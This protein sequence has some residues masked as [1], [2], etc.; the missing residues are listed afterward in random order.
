MGPGIVAMTVLG[1]GIERVLQRDWS[2]MAMFVLLLVGLAAA[3]WLLQRWI[4]YG[5]PAGEAA[6]SGK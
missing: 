1:A 4:G 2:G 3:G 6:A 5:A